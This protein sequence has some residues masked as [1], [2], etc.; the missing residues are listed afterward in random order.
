MLFL[1]M[2][3]F[4]CN[5]IINHLIAKNGFQ[6]LMAVDLI[7]PILLMWPI[8]V[9]GY[10]NIVRMIAAEKAQLRLKQRE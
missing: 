1:C 6:T 10:L 7:L 3:I 2:F 4:I 5:N 8:L 9:L